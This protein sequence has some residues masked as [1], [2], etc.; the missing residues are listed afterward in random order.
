MHALE[1]TERL[2][3]RYSLF[4]GSIGAALFAADSMDGRARYP[5]LDSLDPE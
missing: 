5:V 1:Q 3:A 4:T 2:P